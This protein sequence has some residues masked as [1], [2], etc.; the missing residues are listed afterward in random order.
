MKQPQVQLLARNDLDLSKWDTA[1]K[2][3]PY[4][5]SWWLDAVTQSNWHGLVIDNYRAVMPL[6][7]S[8]SLGPLKL[9]NGAPFTQHQGPFGDCQAEDIERMLSAIPN[10][11]LVR[12]MAIYPP[13]TGQPSSLRWKTTKR[14]NHEL[15]LSPS[16]PT[17]VRGYRGNLR[18][19]L[20]DFPPTELSLLPLADFLDFYQKHVGIKSGLNAREFATLKEVTTSILRHEAGNCYHLTDDAGGTIAAL[21]LVQNGQRI[22]NLLAAS[23]PEGFRL[24]GMT[25]LLDGVIRAHAGTDILL[26][27]EGSDLP[28]VALFFRGFGAER[29]GYWALSRKVM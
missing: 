26:D 2:R 24:H 4:G 29:V 9:I 22:F 27:F 8:R 20:R 25:R 21:L 13:W 18:R 17:L 14:A 3:A 15:D 19:K 7:V 23:S 6:P 12:K 10:H 16:Y 1:V 28:G 11:W 5:L